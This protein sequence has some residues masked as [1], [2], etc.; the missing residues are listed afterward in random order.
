VK[1]YSNEND[2]NNSLKIHLIPGLYNNTPIF[3]DIIN[4]QI[5]MPYINDAILT[6]VK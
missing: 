3:Y 6:F 4:K 5:Y 2:L 1:V